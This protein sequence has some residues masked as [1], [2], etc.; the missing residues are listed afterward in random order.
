MLEAFKS[1]EGLILL[2]L[3]ILAAGAVY[4][5]VPYGEIDFFGTR[6]LTTWGIIAVVAGFLGVQLLK[7]STKHSTL[8]VTT[9]F[10]L[11]AL[12]R[13][14]VDGISDPTSHNLAPFE[15]LIVV[16]IALPPS[17]VGAWVASMLLKE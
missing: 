17:F 15:L 3:V 16:V 8:L 1:K 4:W 6:F 2:V 10:V 9:G 7:Q 11:S 5:P 13:I 12:L 14:I